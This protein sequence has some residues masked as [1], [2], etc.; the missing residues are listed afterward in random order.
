MYSLL[1]TGSH[2]SIKEISLSYRNRVGLYQ[3][4]LDTI[5]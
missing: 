1:A 2:V 4:V 5:T 3:G